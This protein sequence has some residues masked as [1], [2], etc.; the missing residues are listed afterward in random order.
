MATDPLAR[1]VRK[2]PQAI[3]G[4]IDDTLVILNLEAEGAYHHLNRTGRRVWE[5]MDGGPTLAGICG[6]LTREFAVDPAAC[7]ADVSAFV[8][9]LVERKVAILEPS[10]PA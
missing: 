6:A 10:A 3:A 5:L 7:A 9:R 1:I 4:P 2:A 8:D